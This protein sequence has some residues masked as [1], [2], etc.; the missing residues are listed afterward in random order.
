MK[1]VAIIGHFG[2]GKKFYDGQTIKTRIFAQ[3]IEKKVGQENVIHI[4]T[5]GWKKHPILL[6]LNCAKSV[7]HSKNVVFLTDEGGIKI[8]PWL[9]LSLNAFCRRKLHYVVVGGWLVHFPQKHRFIAACI[10]RLDGVWVE[11][12]YMK[13][14]LEALNFRNINLLPN[15]KN[16]HPISEEQLVYIKKEPY[17]FCTFSRVMKEKGIEDAINAINEINNEYGRTVCKLDIFLTEIR[18]MDNLAYCV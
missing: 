12:N 17:L 6:L 7:F 11:T 2:E 9:L 13:K 5:F 15:F 18:T 8:F 3:E 16:L 10:K 14:E 1:K 4:D